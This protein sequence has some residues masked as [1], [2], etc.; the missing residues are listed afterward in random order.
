M[1]SAG[2]GGLRG[3]CYGDEREAFVF[4]AGQAQFVPCSSEWRGVRKGG[5]LLLGWARA[6][7]QDTVLHVLSW[8]Y[9][10]CTTTS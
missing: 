9:L 7:L 4:E 3:G 10:V 1:G 2:G 6:G 5:G 8:P